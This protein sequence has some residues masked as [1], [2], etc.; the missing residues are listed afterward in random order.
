MTLEAGV[1]F[2][3]LAGALILF[4]SGWVRPDIVALLVLTLLV[5]AGLLPA[6][7]ALSGFASDAVIATAGLLILSAGLVR[8]GV[9]RWIAKQLN[10]IAG[11]GPV[12]LVALSTV[13]PGILSGLVSDIGTVSLFIPVIL[14]LARKYDVSRRRLLL[15]LA[16]A[17]LAGG[18]LT[19]IGSSHN[20]VVNSLMQE[21]G[22][23]E[24]GFFEI[25]PIG[26][27]LV[28]SF[29]LY[30][31]FLGRYLLP[32]GEAE[33]D[34]PKGPFDQA[35]IEA[36]GLND[37]LWEVWVGDESSVGGRAVHEL[38]LGEDYGLNLLTV[39]RDEKNR[40]VTGGDMQ[41]ATD[42]TLLIEGRRERVQA[43]AEA[44]PR[45][46]LMGHPRQ[47]EFF[48]ASN[49]E[50]IEVVVPPR[51]RVVGRTLVELNLRAE[52]GLNAVAIW[53]ENQPHRTDVGEMALE[54]GDAVLLYGSRDHSR[55]FDPGQAFLWLHRPYEEAAPR[56]LRHLGPWAFIIMLLVI[57]GSAL[58]LVPI[59]VASLAGSAAMV[60]L[61]ILSPKSLYEH[62][63]WRTVVLIGAMY[64]LG[65]AM[66]VTGASQI[67][68][69]LLLETFGTFGPLVAL[70]S[71]LI[72]SMLL[73]QP[74]HGAAVVIIMTP[75]A[76]ATAAS[77]DVE[78]RAF[79][80]A[81]I[82]GA[83]STYLLPVGHPAPLLVRGPGN[84]E[85]RD[86]VK[87][88]VGLVVITLAMSGVLLPWI[89][90]F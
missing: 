28:I 15:P 77:L 82:V 90:P 13:F 47:Q 54:A 73:T 2:A 61:G 51:S 18:N 9:M 5:M 32:D 86:Y 48:P 64:P 14:R 42:D 81:V 40:L 39:V 84:Y 45:L 67:I 59:S 4:V 76:F 24:L 26:A 46:K 88:G 74:L 27:A 49:A 79:L 35:L 58:E 36:Y 1:V 87:F 72:V 57:L 60:L 55:S 89:W 37:R 65:L 22:L 63:E 62:V 71:M 30:T 6:E 34:R 56:E 20:L 7:E 33:L 11:S 69:T 21:A 53:R 50:L 19:L 66:E 41:V 80:I 10:S 78:P 31:F 12:G 70:L 83:A 16:M 38:E 23:P 3:I 52:S 25:A 75:I 43:F 44:H 17:V 85:P 29:A 8:S 68:A